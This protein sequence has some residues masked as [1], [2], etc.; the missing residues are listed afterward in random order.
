M[1][2]ETPLDIEKNSLRLSQHDDDYSTP[3]SST[4]SSS[5]A[6]IKGVDKQLLFQQFVNTVAIL[7]YF[8]CI[9][10]ATSIDPNKVFFI[11]TDPRISFPYVTSQVSVEALVLISSLVPAF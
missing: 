11:E 7:I 6:S 4:G 5:S 9:Y 10:F 3:L 8:I 2:K 1:L